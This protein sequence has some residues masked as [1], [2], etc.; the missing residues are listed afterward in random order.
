MV[1]YDYSATQWSWGNGEKGSGIFWQRRRDPSIKPSEKWQKYLGKL[2]VLTSPLTASASEDFFGPLV[3][4]KRATTVGQP[5]CGSTGNPLHFSLPG[6]GSFRVC[7][8]YVLLPDNKE[9]IGIGIQ[10]DIKVTPNL[11]DVVTGKDPVLQCAI[12]E[13]KDAL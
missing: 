2:V 7:T 6:G 1:I 13:C 9:F 10:P 12:K 3:V 5:T 11:K 8:R 4:G